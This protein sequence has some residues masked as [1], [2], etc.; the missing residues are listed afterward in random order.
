MDGAPEW[1]FEIEKNVTSLAGSAAEEGFDAV[2]VLF[3]VD[4]DGVEVGGFDVDVDAVFEEAELLEALGL[5]EGAGGKGG[6]ALECGFAVGV[7]A[8]VFPVLRRG[9]MLGA[10]VVGDGGAGEVEGSSVG[11]GDYFDCVW[12]GDV[13]GSAEDFE[14]GDFDVRLCKGAEEGSEMFGFEEGLVALDVDVDVGRNLLRDGMDAVGAAGQVGGGELDGPVV[15]TAEVGY[16]FGVGGDD[17]AV[18]LRAGGGGFVDPGEHGSAG[19]G[20]KD[21]TGETGGGEA[22]RDDAEDGCGPLF[23]R[24]G[25]KYDGSWLCRGDRL[26]PEENFVPA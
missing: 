1:L 12:V 26:S 19:D 25:I 4:A 10:S 18:E 22:C 15:L 23:A 17:D 14:R 16:F 13:L 9:V 7:Q 3:G 24:C 6:E 8:Y 5:F 20:A 11:G 21:F 2:E